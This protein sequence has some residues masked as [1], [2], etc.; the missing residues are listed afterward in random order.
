[1]FIHTLEM[2]PK[3][4]YLELEVQEDNRLG[5]DHLEFQGNIEF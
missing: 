1:M 3:N 4:W 5:R 2:V